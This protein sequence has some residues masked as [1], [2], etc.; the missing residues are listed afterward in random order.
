M[1]NNHGLDYGIAGL[2]DTLQALESQN[3]RLVG[4]GRIDAEADRPLLIDLAGGEVPL[5]IAIFAS[6]LAPQ[7]TRDAGQARRTPEVRASASPTPPAS[8]NRCGR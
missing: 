6:Y 1:A 3:I 7:R 8:P 4:T 2:E 5:R